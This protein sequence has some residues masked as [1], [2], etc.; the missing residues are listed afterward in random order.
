MTDAAE[1]PTGRGSRPGPSPRSETSL[2]DVAR[3]AGVSPSTA[4]RVVS[5]SSHPVSEESR[6]R[7]LEAAR[8][9]RFQPNRLARA[10]ATARSQ[11][12]GVLVHDAAD[13]YFAQIIRG[14][15]D[16]VGE[17]DHA[18]FVASSDRDLETELACISAFHSHQ[19][20]AIV[21]AASGMASPDYADEIAGLLDR[22]VDR[23][24]VVV[25][26]STG[27]YP[28]PGV[29][30]DNQDVAATATRH[31]IELG[32]RRI[33]YLAGPG[34]LLVTRERRQGYQTALAEAGIGID[35]GIVF[36]SGFT[37][38]GGRE[39]SEMIL[40]APGTT[41]VVAAND[42]VA[43]GAIR[44]LMDHGL[45]VP[46][47]ISVVGIDDILFTD[48]A[49][50]PLTTVRIPLIEL[51]RVGARMV[52]ALLRGETVGDQV[53]AH[54]LVIRSSTAPPRGRG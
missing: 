46:D 48:Y 18:L 29:H 15:E 24:G 34:Q 22:F 41:G 47:D 8:N 33:A 28:A 20:D 19:V 51:G 50:V 53:L 30:V 40:A 26:L 12:I 11:T 9:L 2:R 13:P 43:I 32:H 10:L 54:R 31:L 3:L 35:P 16:I 14:I 27:S 4:S 52:M 5:G 37:L 45:T 23:G 21:L 36:E 44:G 17:H 49:P 38:E 39:M 1:P 7:V 6:A 25:S 42:L